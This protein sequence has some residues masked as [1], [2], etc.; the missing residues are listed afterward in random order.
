M[1]NQFIFIALV[2]TAAGSMLYAKP[3]D[4]ALRDPFWPIGYTPPPPVSEK[5]VRKAEP[6]S[7]PKKP[8]PPP[9]P[10]P[11]TEE[12]WKMARKLL[13]ISGYALAKNTKDKKDNKNEIVIINRNY[14]N[15]GDAVKIIHKDIEFIWRVGKILNNSVDLQQESAT[16]LKNK[17]ADVP[18]KKR[19]S[20]S[21]VP[22][23][24]VPADGI[25]K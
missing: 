25:M 7:E 1:K 16:R 18:D 12:D 2:V 9:P 4:K 11:V 3:E 21:P 23:P 24:V 8:E 22:I 19:N 6:V 10:K 17:S 14:Y 20:R 13:K 5:P 15:T